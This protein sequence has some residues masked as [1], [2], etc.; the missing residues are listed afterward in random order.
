MPLRCPSIAVLT[1]L[2]LVSSALRAGDWPQWRGPEGNSVSSET[3]LP[4]IWSESQNIR[5]KTALPPWGNSTPAIWGEAT[6][7]HDA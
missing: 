4:L 1:W 2:V 7:P 6:L 3:N 5:W